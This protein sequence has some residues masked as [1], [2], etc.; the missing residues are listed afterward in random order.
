MHRS[1][2]AVG[3][4][5]VLLVA[6]ALLGVGDLSRAAAAAPDAALRVARFSA[7]ASALD[8]RLTG[9]A[10]VGSRHLLLP[11]GASPA[12]GGYAAI[13]PG[14]Y[15]V[16]VRSGTASPAV[17]TVD[18]QPGAAYTLGLFATAGTL[19][20]MLVH[21]DLTP[22]PPGSGRVR[23]ILAAGR[24]RQADVDL[25]S[26]PVLAHHADFATVTAYRSVPAGTWR[27]AASCTSGRLMRTVAPVSLAEGNLTSIVLFDAPRGGLAVRVLSDATGA[28][29]S[30]AGAIPAGGGGMAAVISGHTPGLPTALIGSLELLA[31]FAAWAVLHAIVAAVRRRRTADAGALR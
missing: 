8:V 18:A 2:R 1:W 11:P 6:A 19:Q 16:T 30:P 24:A 13:L 23:L 12:V 7:D 10:G 21:D 17:L 25:V 29:R 4:A 22:P 9:Y 31:V 20:A 14:L 27:V 28:G 26:G 5:V 15:V 3:A